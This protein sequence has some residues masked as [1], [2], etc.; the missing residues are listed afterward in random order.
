MQKRLLN[1][2]NTRPVARS[3]MRTH[4]PDAK[5][6]MKIFIAAVF[7]I[8]C[9]PA[10]LT[11]AVADAGHNH[12]ATPRY[13]GVVA[14]LNHLTYELVARPDAIALYVSVHGAPVDLRK[15]SASVTIHGGR[16]R[17]SADL[18]PAGA[19]KLEAKGPFI[20]GAGAKA[21]VTVRLQ[22]DAA[23]IA[24]SFALP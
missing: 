11:P 21:A 5:G 19:N 2:T 10:A 8:A 23:P 6:L 16:E 7:A 1:P 13:G 17:I 3:R 22:P 4:V 14:T 12:D 9:S 15:G 20:I 18:V 24:L